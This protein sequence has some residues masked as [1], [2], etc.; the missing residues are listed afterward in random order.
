MGRT[1]GKSEYLA[2]LLNSSSKRVNA[3]GWNFK[4]DFPFHT[5]WKMVVWLHRMLSCL[6]KLRSALTPWSWRNLH[7]T[8]RKLIAYRKKKK[9]FQGNQEKKYILRPYFKNVIWSV[10]AIKW[11]KKTLKKSCFYITHIFPLNSLYL[12]IGLVLFFFLLHVYF[13]QGECGSFLCAFSSFFFLN[14]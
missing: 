8:G 5:W 9:K 3:E 4:W 1:S 10:H 6:S 11:P 2:T 14:F 12:I 13:I 7:A